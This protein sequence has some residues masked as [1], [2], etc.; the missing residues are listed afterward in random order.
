[1]TVRTP[2]REM[3][4]AWRGR[5]RDGTPRSGTVIAFDAA[6]ARAGLAR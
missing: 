3:R 2:P 5:R 1:M 6:A 4:F